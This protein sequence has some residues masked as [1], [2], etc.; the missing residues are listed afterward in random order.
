MN[1]IVELTLS[2]QFGY[3]YINIP[4]ETGANIERMV[5]RFFRTTTTKHSEDT[6]ALMLI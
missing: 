6:T 5:G 4:Q 2:P 1:W 3:D